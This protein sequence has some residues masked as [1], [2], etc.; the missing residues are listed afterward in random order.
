MNQ[1]DS[2]ETGKAVTMKEEALPD[3]QQKSKEYSHAIPS[4]NGGEKVPKRF[5]I[6][7]HGR[8]GT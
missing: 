6:K 3:N 5:L 8:V 4:G 7:R 2:L 1:L